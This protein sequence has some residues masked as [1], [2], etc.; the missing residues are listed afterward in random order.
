MRKR[1]LTPNTFHYNLLLRVIRDCGMG[2]DNY[3]MEILG[4]GGPTQPDHR[5]TSY[6]GVSVQSDPRE[7]SGKGY[8]DRKFPQKLPIAEVVTNDHEYGTLSVIGGEEL[9]DIEVS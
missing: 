3:A 4:G 2:D 9:K 8:S 5:P 6:S 7:I 1:K